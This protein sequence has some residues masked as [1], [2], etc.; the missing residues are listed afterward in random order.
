MI[1]CEDWGV[2][3]NSTRGFCEWFVQKF[4]G[5]EARG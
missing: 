4:V 1:C 5:K 3:V 2:D